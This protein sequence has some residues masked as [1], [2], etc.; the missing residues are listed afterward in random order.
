M[1]DGLPDPGQIWNDFINP[2]IIYGPREG[3][4]IMTG[5]YRSLGQYA[6]DFG[7][8]FALML[9]ATLSFN[10]SVMA[11]LWERLDSC[12]KRRLVCRSSR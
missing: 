6:A 7:G 11:T 12:G 10:R 5:I 1:P 4:T 3:T 2:L 9:L 8:M